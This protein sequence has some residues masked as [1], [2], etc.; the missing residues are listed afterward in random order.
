MKAG[1]NKW[2]VQWLYQGTGLYPEYSG[3]PKELVHDLIGVLERM[4]Q[5]LGGKQSAERVQTG[6]LGK[7]PV[8]NF[9]SKAAVT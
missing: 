1:H 5:L 2:A 6:K 7:R 8:Q 9:Q 4:P 3:K